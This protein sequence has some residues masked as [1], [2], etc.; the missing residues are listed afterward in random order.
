MNN[1]VVWFK[2]TTEGWAN[3][4]DFKTW[5]DTQEQA[6][7]PVELVYKIATPFDIDI[8][9]EQIEALVGVN[10]VWHDGNGD[11]EVKYLEVVRN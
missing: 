9:P 2:S 6:N 7:T 3:V 1:T 8:T 4:D 5:L 11:T 10:N